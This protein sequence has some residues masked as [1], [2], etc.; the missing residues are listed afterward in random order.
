MNTI[1]SLQH[2]P[3]QT[4][5]PYVRFSQT[6]VNYLHT[7]E[8]SAPSG[9]IRAIHTDAAMAHWQCTNIR[10]VLFSVIH[11]HRS[12]I[13]TQVPY[14]ICTYPHY[15]YVYIYVTFPN[16]YNIE[17]RNVYLP[18]HL[19]WRRVL[20]SGSKATY[21]TAGCECGDQATAS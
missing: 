14:A 1:T 19:N 15:T 18:L 21:Y 13:H 7:I 4:R 5:S 8:S 9:Y 20:I 2:L 10:L 3:I 11:I 17:H 12:K 6:K 16:I